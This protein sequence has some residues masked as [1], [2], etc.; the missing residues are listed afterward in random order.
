MGFCWS[1]VGLNYSFLCCYQ[2]NEFFL[3]GFYVIEFCLI[4]ISDLSWWSSNGVC[5]TALI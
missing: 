1:F 4:V 5:K 3:K 2:P